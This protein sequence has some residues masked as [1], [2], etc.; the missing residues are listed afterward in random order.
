MSKRRL[1]LISD[2]KLIDALVYRVDTYGPESQSVT[3]VRAEILA[4]LKARERALTIKPTA[5]SW[6]DDD[7]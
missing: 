7:D 2:E 5:F 4:R 3:R 1:A 6:I